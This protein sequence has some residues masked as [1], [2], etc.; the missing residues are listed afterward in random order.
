LRRFQLQQRL[1]A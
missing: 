1:S